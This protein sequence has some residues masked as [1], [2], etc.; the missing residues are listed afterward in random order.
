LHD[1]GALR[2]VEIGKLA[3]RPERRQPVHARLDEVVAET[4][5]H[6]RADLARGIDR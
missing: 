4:A 3:G 2:A 5:E 6:V 1:A